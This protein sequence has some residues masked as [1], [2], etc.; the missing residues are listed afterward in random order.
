MKLR[1]VLAYLLFAVFLSAAF[2]Q[3]SGMEE[4]TGD[5]EIAEQYVRWA[6]QAIDEGRWPQALAGLER[7]ADFASASSDISYLLALARSHEGRSRRAVLEALGQA[8]QTNRWVNYSESQA[9]LMQA[10]QLSAMRHYSAALAAL[11][12]VPQSADTAGLRLL[13]LRGMAL[14]AAHAAGEPVMALALFRRSVLETMDRY[15]R[16]PRPLRI[17]LEYAR[18]RHPEFSALTESDN[19]LMELVL[20]R[21]PFLLEDDPELAWLAAPF[22]RDAAQARRLVASYRAGALPPVQSEHFFPSPGSIAA[23]LNLGLLNDSEAVEEL[24][25]GQRVFDNRPAVTGGAGFFPAGE[26]ALDVETIVETS[27]LLRSDEGRD[28]F[29]R[30]LLSFSGIITSGREGHIETSAFYRDGSLREFVYDADNDS[31]ADFRVVFG[32]D[33]APLRAERLLLPDLETERPALPQREEDLVRALIIWERYPSVSRAE[34]A[35]YRYFFRPADYHYSPLAFLELCGSKSYSG[36]MY[37][38]IS[39]ENI[40]LSR[41]SL[42]ASCASL[43]RPSVE[44]EGA[45]EQIDLYRGIPLR[46]VEVL[47]GRQV[48]V[49]EFEAGLPVIQY[50]DLDLDGRMETVRRFRRPVS[51]PEAEDFLDFRSLIESSLSDWSGEGIH[52]TGEMYPD[53]GSVVYS[54][55]LDGDGSWDYSESGNTR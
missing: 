30:R 5:A 45:V 47:N 53:D 23:A 27:D 40:M 16:D 42:V 37:P 39:H 2:A 29:A 10:R 7:A 50:I 28:M 49:T 14:N 35:G 20:R 41:R 15:P 51:L 17:F 36:L 43:Q 52:R 32:A 11:D 18:N 9:R 44:F 55:D 31:L 4:K 1:P 13:A 46:A 8:L 34:L 24:F 19:N 3:D 26:I 22:I 48:S 38:V 6:Q 33:Y 54:W 25:D 21:L 12:N